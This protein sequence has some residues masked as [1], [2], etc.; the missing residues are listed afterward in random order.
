MGFGF[1]GKE[2]LT[3]L[4]WSHSGSKIVKYH[5][6]LLQVSLSMYTQVSRVQRVGTPQTSS[7]VD[8]VSTIFYSFLLY[9]TFPSPVTQTDESA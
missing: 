9:R 4:T 1:T 8:A 3:K 7:F 5:W 2:T 6:K